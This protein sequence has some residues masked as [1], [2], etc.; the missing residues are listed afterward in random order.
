MSEVSKMSANASV[1]SAEREADFWVFG[2]IFRP[3]YL[4]AVPRTH[5]TYS[6]IDAKADGKMNLEVV[7][8]KELAQAS[9]Q[10]DIFDSQTGEK[11]QSFTS[12]AVASATK[13]LLANASLSDINPWSSENPQLYRAVI[14]LLERGK[15]VHQTTERFGFRT[16]EVRDRDE[17]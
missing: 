1:N 3:V 10:V 16:V 13:R 12:T 17:L 5:M 2:G 8:D 11:K 4:E 7:L 15:P 6:G 9:L 14:M